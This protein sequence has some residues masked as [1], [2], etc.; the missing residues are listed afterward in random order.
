MIREW[1]RGFCKPLRQD[2]V[3]MLRVATDRQCLTMRRGFL[4]VEATRDTL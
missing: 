4:G 1:R 3:S 2:L